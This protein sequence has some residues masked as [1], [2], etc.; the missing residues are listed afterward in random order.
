MERR[1]AAILAADVVG[2]SRLMERDEADTLAR[3]KALRRELVQPRI[4]AHKGRIVKLMGDG[5]LA[6]FPSAVEAV[7]C[8]AGI[9]EAMTEREAGQPDERRIKL[10]I[11]VNIGDII[12]ERSDIYGDGVNVAARLEGLAEPG[13]ICISGPAFDAIDGKLDLAFDDIGA[14]RVKNIAKP[15]RAYR[16]ATASRREASAAPSRGPLQLPD[17]PSIA[18]LPFANMSGD[19]EQEYFS[20]GITEDIIT[21]LSRFRTLF[22]IARNS[23]FTF[24]DRS[25]SASRI[26]TELGVQYIVEGSVRKSAKRVRVTAQLIEAESGNHLWAERYDRDLEDIFAVQDEV[27]QAIVSALPGRLDAAAVERGRKRPTESLTAYDC[28]LRGEWYLRRG[29]FDDAKARVLFEKAA[30]IDP[31]SARAQ[32]RIAAWHAYSIYSHEV[33]VERAFGKAHE[34]IA[35]ALELENHDATIHAI[36]AM[37]YLHRAEHALT[38]THIERAMALNPNDVEVLYRRAMTA[39]YHGDPQAGLA[40][41]RKAMR[42]DPFYPDY[43]LEVLFDA[44]YLSGDYAAAAEAFRRWRDPPIH[45]YA[46]LAAAC[47][48]M[49][50]MAAAAKAVETYERK[51]PEEHD[52]TEFVKRHTRICKHQAGRDRWLEGYRKAGFPV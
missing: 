24:K 29:D 46:E 36:A 40:W 7:R 43:W 18:V 49:G 51:R 14:Q 33:S 9:Q 30:E 37:V 35:R 39:V 11:G 34:H 8:A 44:S 10:R 26:G 32:A 16:L 23:S 31:N 41:L 15:V 6:D 27:T 47:A 17:K 21:E 52:I 1:L 5:L 3:L 48:Q 20:D 25:V 19:P 28:L 13:G 12:V 4:A 50:D 2:F 42:L 45:M 38:E 22:V